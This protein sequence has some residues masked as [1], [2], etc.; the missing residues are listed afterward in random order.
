M[1][2]LF[3]VLLLGFLTLSFSCQSNQATNKDAGETTTEANSGSTETPTTTGSDNYTV[4]VLKADIPS[5]RK[6]MKADIGGG[7]VSVN[8]GSPSAKGRNLWGGLVPWD[9]VWRAGANEATTFEVSKD[10]TI[11]G[12]SLAA[13]KYGF[14]IHPK[15][16]EGVAW[17]II[18]NK[19]AEQ[20]GAYDYDKSKDAARAMATPTMIGE[21]S[22]TMDFEVEGSNLI[23][24]WGKLKL[25]IAISG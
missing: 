14:F 22:E 8:Y 18:F 20:W 10:I 16:G 25:P 17:E 13:G 21:A 12:A 1:R 4:T 9:K 23:L 7:M 24:R 5:P 3:A 6:E 2:N 19:V 15:K 11:G